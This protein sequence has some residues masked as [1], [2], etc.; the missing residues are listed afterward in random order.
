MD[1]ASA[2]LGQR[3]FDVAWKVVGA[4]VAL[5][6]G[7]MVL[8]AVRSM[9]RGELA[10]QKP[11][12]D[13]RGVV[14]PPLALTT[15]DGTRLDLAAERGR[16]VLIVAFDA[17]EADRKL[18]ADLAER[19]RTAAEATGGAA[20]V[21]GL[22]SGLPAAE[23]GAAVGALSPVA[24]VADTDRRAAEAL[25]TQ[26]GGIGSWWIVD[27]KGRIELRG[28]PMDWPRYQAFRA[29]RHAADP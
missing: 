24:L 17:R 18:L 10:E 5:L 9:L 26:T 27:R 4:G 7:A 11:I 19:A 1:P 22:V 3:I 12:W 25:R 29:L 8:N 14:A 2:A 21:W 20:R 6:A 28:A 15:T 16:A 23:V 13:P